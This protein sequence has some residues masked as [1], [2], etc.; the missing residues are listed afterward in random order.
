MNSEEILIEFVANGDRTHGE[1]IKSISTN[2]VKE[3]IQRVAKLVQQLATESTTNQSDGL[4]LDEVEVAIKLTATG[5]AVLLGDGQSNGAITLRFR[6]SSKVV[7]SAGSAPA[8]LTPSTGISYDKLQNLL[9]NSKWQ[10]AN[11]ETWNLMCQAANKN[12]GSVLSA[13][14]IKQIPCEVLQTIDG[15]WQKHSQGHYGFSS[16]NQIYMSSILG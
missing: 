13:E 12:L 3:S 4:A 8:A 6:R 11:Q 15:L 10:D 7:A 9:T 14:D 1:S 5:E 2:K 16:Q